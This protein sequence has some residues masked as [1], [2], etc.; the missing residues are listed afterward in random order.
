VAASRTRSDD[1]IRVHA[2]AAMQ[3]TQG[4]RHLTPVE[5]TV[6]RALVEQL[7]Q[8]YGRDLLRV[9][10]YGSKAR[11]DANAESDL[12]VLVVLRLAGRDYWSHWRQ[13]TD[14]AYDL[15]L[16]HGVVL[17]LLIRDEADYE[18]MR[19]WGLLIHRCIERDGIDLWT[20]LPNEPSSA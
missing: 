10:L 2:R 17:S 20:S 4:L 14:A 18:R 13:I 12:D 6:L 5:R 8:C 11:G 7:C 1:R 16:E 9:V 19:Q 3:A 15:A